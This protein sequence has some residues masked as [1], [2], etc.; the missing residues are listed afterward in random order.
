[1]EYAYQPEAWHEL[2]L[3]V[4]TAAAGLTGL[5]FVAVSLHLREVLSN[6]WHRGTAGSSLLALM[7]VVLISGAL[8]APP[9]PLPLLGA[10]IAV[11]ALLSPAYDSLALLHLP[12]ERRAPAV[13][14]VLLGMVG[15][16]LAVA[17]GVSLA[18][19]AGGGLWLLLP[20]AA[21]ALGSAVLNAWRLM[22]DVAEGPVADRATSADPHGADAGDPPPAGP[23]GADA[24]DPPPADPPGEA[25][26][27]G[28][29]PQSVP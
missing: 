29:D 21:I 23:D 19:E 7:S 10:E 22:V 5:I 28:V 16:F 17:A 1:M 8:L 15:G 4:G 2:Y 18:I 14:K 3:M 25:R 9:Q 6:P 11:I 12:R 27:A 26:L 13:A 24:G 20:A